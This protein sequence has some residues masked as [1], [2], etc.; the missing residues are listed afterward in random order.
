MQALC[1]ES[2]QYEWMDVMDLMRG[3]EYWHG[4][5]DGTTVN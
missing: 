4:K 3:I 5:T 2:E 1:A